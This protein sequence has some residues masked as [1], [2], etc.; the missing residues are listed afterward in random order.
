MLMS[1]ISIRNSSG[2]KPDLWGAPEHHTQS[3]KFLVMIS[4]LILK[5]GSHLGL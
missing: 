4:A 5:L 2:P 1:I 3:D